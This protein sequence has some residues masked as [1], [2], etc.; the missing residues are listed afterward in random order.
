[1]RKHTLH[2]YIN[3]ILAGEH[4][5]AYTDFLTDITDLLNDGENVIAIRVDSRERP[6]VPPFGGVVDYL[7]YG[8]IYR[9]VFLVETPEIYIADVYCSSPNLLEK[10]DLS[11]KISVGYGDANVSVFIKDGDSVIAQSD[12]TTSGGKAEVYFEN[13]SV[14]LWSVKTP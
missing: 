5:C 12:I 3:G 4:K 14:D 8:G 10:R 6:D 7:C 13:L 2:G 1:M 11:V 9:E